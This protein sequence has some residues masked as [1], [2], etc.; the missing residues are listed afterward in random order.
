[1]SNIGDLYVCPLCWRKFEAD[2][3]DQVENENEVEDDDEDNE[4]DG[5]SQGSKAVKGKRD[6]D[7]ISPMEALVRAGAEAAKAC[8]RSKRS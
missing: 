3:Q 8:F 2:A 7:S 1:M 4:D 5:S 6:L